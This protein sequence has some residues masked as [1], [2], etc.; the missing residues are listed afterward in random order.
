[1][2]A[3]FALFRNPLA[4]P[5]TP[6]GRVQETI[7]DAAGHKA[8]FD[9]IT[10][11]PGYEATPLVALDDV[12]RALGVAAVAYKDEAGRFGDWPEDFDEVHLNAQSEFLDASLDLKRNR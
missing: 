1:M 9:E 7:M 8:A 4:L 3:G 2:A 11:W 6:Y 10:R 5:E 12:A